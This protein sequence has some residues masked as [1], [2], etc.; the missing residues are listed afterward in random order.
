MAQVGG[1]SPVETVL[2]AQRKYADLKHQQ[3]EIG[4]TI[5][6][7]FVRGIRHIG[8]RSNVDAIA[9]LIDNSIQA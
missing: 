2:L 5:P 6:E 9:E 3:S 1:I 7:A 4:L 8:Y